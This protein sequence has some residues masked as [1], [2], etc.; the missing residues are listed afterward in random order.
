MAKRHVA[1]E[2]WTKGMKGLSNIILELRYHAGGSSLQR[3]LT[4]S[5]SFKYLARSWNKNV[6]DDI[7]NQIKENQKSLHL[8][9]SQLTDNPMDLSLLE[10]NIDLTK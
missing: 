3:F 2:L 9:Q 6:F 5:I 7:F 1:D 10:R 8:I 4:F